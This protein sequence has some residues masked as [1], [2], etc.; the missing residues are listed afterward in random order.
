MVRAPL[1]YDIISV[2][3]VRLEHG[4]SRVMNAI[5]EMDGGGASGDH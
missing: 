1:A 2:S 3:E 5:S 4:T